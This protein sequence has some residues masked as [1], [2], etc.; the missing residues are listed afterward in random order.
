MPGFF[1]R[2]GMAF[3]RKRRDPGFT[4]VATL[5][6]DPLTAINALDS[7]NAKVDAEQE[8]IKRDVTKMIDQGIG[9]VTDLWAPPRMKIQSDYIEMGDECLSTFTVS[10]W[11]TSLHYGWLTDVIDDSNL[12]DIKMDVSI[13]IHPIKKAYAIAYMDDKFAS[14]QSS[15]E[16]EMQRGKLKKEN[17]KIYTR[18]MD[19]AGEI[20]RLLDQPNENLFQVALVFGI[21]GEN[22]WDYDE[23]N[24]PVLIRTAQEDVIEKTKRVKKSLSKNSGG[25]FE[26]KPL[27]HQQREG[28]KSL[29]PW[30]YGGLHAF[31][32]FYTSA[33]AT[34]YPFTHGKL[35][36]EGGIYYGVSI[37]SGQPI[38]FDNF[39]KQ[40]LNNFSTIVLGSS[41][42]GKRMPDDTTIYYC[43]TD[44]DERIVGVRRGTLGDVKPGE[45]ILGGDGKPCTVTNVFPQGECSDNFVMRLSDGRRSVSGG[46]HLWDVVSR[47]DDGYDRHIVLSTA[48]LKQLM[49]A[50]RH[51]GYN[52]LR[53]ENVD[54]IDFTEKDLPVDPF[55]V[56]LVIRLVASGASTNDAIEELV[57]DGIIDID[58]VE[59]RSSTL[60]ALTSLGAFDGRIPSTYLM[61][62]AQQREQLLSGI[63]G[64][65]PSGEYA[66]I[67]VVPFDGNPN[68]DTASDI[69]TLA[70][71]LGRSCHETVA[72]D[73]VITLDM[74]DADVDSDRV[75]LHNRVRSIHGFDPWLIGYAATLNQLGRF[76][77][78]RTHRD[79][80]ELDIPK[81]D[82]M[83]VND[84]VL[85]GF[86]LVVQRE[87]EDCDGYVTATLDVDDGVLSPIDA[88]RYRTM[89]RRFGYGII[90]SSVGQAIG[91]G[92]DRK[93]SRAFIDGCEFA[94]AKDDDGCVAID[95]PRHGMSFAFEVAAISGACG[96]A[97][98]VFKCDSG[99][100][101]RLSEPSHIG[102]CV[103]ING[104]E[105]LDEP[106]KMTCIQVDNYDSTFVVDDMLRT[107]NSATVKTLLGRYALRGTQIFIIDPAATQ[108]GEYTNL[109]TSLDGQVIDFGGR[110]SLSLNPFELKVPSYWNPHLETDAEKA[111]D[112][113]MNK[114]TY[115]KGMFDIMRG[116]YDKENQVADMNLDVFG[117]LIDVLI[118]RVYQYKGINI[119]DNGWNFN[120]WKIGW[121]PEMNDFYFLLTEYEQIVQDFTDRPAIQGW[122]KKHLTQQGALINKQSRKDRVM[123]G[124][125]RYVI[126]ERNA[127]WG[128]AEYD[129]IHYIKNIVEEYIF[130][131]RKQIY[132]EKSALFSGKRN[133]DLSNQCIVFRFSSVSETMKEL[134]TYLTF[135][136]IYSRI[137]QQADDDGAL[138]DQKILV[139]DEAWKMIRTPSCRQYVE[140][141]IR[142]GRKLKAGLWLITQSFSDV[143]GD[144]AV[145]FNQAE[146]KIVLS[147]PDREVQLL[148]DSLDLSP[149]MADF[150]NNE[151]NDTQPG[152]GIISIGGKQRATV[153]FYC[154]MTALEAA[155]ADTTDTTKPPLTAADIL[156]DDKARAFGLV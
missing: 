133:A 130:D 121:L 70:R 106:I 38:F 4:D 26:I 18:Q 145:F 79:S 95:L 19:T 141:F 54:C 77:I 136:L 45:V 152:F 60:D 147:L 1:G 44:T 9:S 86:V 37:S 34:C 35:Q 46:P 73:G 124:Y 105:E 10:N 129:V 62:S 59:G 115:L 113:Y 110:N 42:S 21:Y 132:S 83:T 88:L 61:S 65:R 31:Q 128:Q 120:Q 117:K 96:L 131:P 154:E 74:F 29:L 92:Y 91:G 82:V 25:G 138:Y 40:W 6:N 30:G 93:Q 122:A 14:A 23:D 107:H 102:N 80:F 142:E 139:M 13:H 48:Q 53:I 89:I 12:T 67:D 101:I 20:R 81:L 143:Q 68:G 2:C 94:A 140:K 39:S 134:A 108:E 41:G 16:A 7:E 8:R 17:E 123:L 150:I 69:M 50:D 85:D 52:A 153:S 22:Q 49:N 33:L 114:K 127:M 66:S 76:R 125:Y 118:D 103:A 78:S 104:I 146:T 100:R 87:D 63:F 5:S 112:I 137:Q 27:L 71:S 119:T 126:M 84:H 64:E 111:I 47:T 43:D 148:S 58:D 109:A 151:R 28:I 75:E 116:I 156:G 36:V 97:S 56:G 155:I 32:N 51:D 144:N 135:E 24:Q 3:G 15:Y 99:V 11:P 57:D 149:N 72:P 55:V 90:A 98:D